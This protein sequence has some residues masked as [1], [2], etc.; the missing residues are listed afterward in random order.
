MAIQLVTGGAGFIGSHLVQALVQ[1]GDQVRILDD[2]SS[3]NEKNL[4]DVI[5]AVEIIR[6]D[7]RDP[8]LLVRAVKGVD[9]IFHH[10]AF[11]SVAESMMKPREC[12]DVNVTG[13]HLLLNSAAQ[14]GVRRV[15]IASSAAVYGEN[16]N[17]PL[18]ETEPACPM[19]PYA[20]SKYMDETLAGL[21]T[22]SYSLGVTCLRYFNVYGPR[23]NPNSPYAAAIPIFIREMHQN[24]PPKVFGDGQQTRDFVQVRDVVRANLMAAENPAAA[25]GVFNICSG[26]K[27]SILDLLE[28]L[29]SLLPN[30]PAPVFTAE[31][32]GEIHH[33]QGCPHLAEQ[34]L[35]FSAEISLEDGLRETCQ[36]ACQ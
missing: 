27:V 18:C 14:A 23:Q 1:R 11:I 20:A 25:G 15:M 21:Y 3:G 29:S 9:T 19:S 35:G 4:A 5:S 31:R 6:G 12:L 13:T 7:L 8:D 33:S 22:R 30:S 16:Q 2:F 24:R 28:T 26:Q 32:K 17:L 36:W 34:V 10:A